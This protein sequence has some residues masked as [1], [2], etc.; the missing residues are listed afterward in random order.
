MGRHLKIRL[1]ESTPKTKFDEMFFSTI[2]NDNVL[3]VLTITNNVT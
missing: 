1:Y 3:T 2:K